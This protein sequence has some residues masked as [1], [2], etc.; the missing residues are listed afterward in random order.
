MLMLRQISRVKRKGFTVVELL[1]VIVVIGILAA[2]TI[3]GYS[4]VQSAAE[5]SRMQAEYDKIENAI[6]IYEAKNGVY[7]VCAAGAS[8]C[9]MS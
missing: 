4:G 6:S 3:V 1:V 8:G 5:I 9:L 2:I 7:P